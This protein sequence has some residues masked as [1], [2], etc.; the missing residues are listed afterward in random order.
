M[1]NQFKA[2][3]IPT[4][5]YESDRLVLYYGLI[6]KSFLELEKIP[7]HLVTMLSDGNILDSHEILRRD[8]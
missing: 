2:I 3:T 1:H 8:N 4:A 7:Y 6:D 5:K